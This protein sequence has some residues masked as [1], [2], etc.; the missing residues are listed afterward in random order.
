MHKKLNP[1]RIFKDSWVLPYLK[2]NRYLLAL[3]VILGTGTFFSAAALMFTSGHL[4]SKSAAVSGNILLVYIP[5]V[6]VRFFGVSRPAFRYAERL[7]SH[8]MTLKILS[9]MRV[10][11]F[12]LLEPQALLM[13]E[14]YRTGDLL[15]M[16]S[17]DIEH[18]EDIY[19]KTIFPTLISLVLFVLIVWALGY[20]SIP[21]ALFMGLMLCVLVVFFPI[22]SLLCTRARQARL[23]DAKNGLYSKLTDAV[24]G[25]GEWMISHRQKEFIQDYQSYELRVD[26]SQ[27]QLSSFNSYRNLLF[28]LCTAAILI[29]MICW[30]G[31]QAEQGSLAPVWIAAFV[32]VVF[33]LIDVFSPLSDAISQIPGYESSLTR[34]NS[35]EKTEDKPCLLAKEQLESLRSCCSLPVTFEQVT[36]SYSQDTSPILKNI[37]LSVNAGEK[38]ALLGKS[39]CGKSTLARL[40]LGA[41][42]P[43]NGHIYIGSHMVSDFGADTVKV[44]SILS[45]KPY[46]FDTTVMNNIR[47]GNLEAT[48]EDVYQAAK[49]VGMHEYFLS[50][51]QGYGTRMQE[52]GGRFSGG[53]RQR[54]A[55]ARIL[56]SKTPIV[57]LDE[58]TV[59]L[60]TFTE[61]R[62]LDTIFDVLRDK[63]VIW[64]THHLAHAEKM[65]RILFLED[66]TFMMQGTHQALLNGNRRYRDLYALDCPEPETFY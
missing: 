53:E 65:D 40:L 57:I 17:E 7:T 60:D 8:S 3:V 51:P 29:A 24:M 20:F 16:L 22:V 52:L 62:L 43:V 64:I 39:G 38:M 58:P 46:L 48:D 35:L 66:G 27:R 10:R 41:Y 14:R 4:I 54:I 45:Q 5:I 36:F 18:L 26:Y 11:L 30:S 15:G 2:K 31:I 55:L 61:R 42:P 59:G 6:L 25:S 49:Q 34:L 50:L 21:F 23:K 13:K 19:V 63:T 9:Q 12:R 56:L 32:L 33:P 47:L 37:S 1:F 28:Q 44:V